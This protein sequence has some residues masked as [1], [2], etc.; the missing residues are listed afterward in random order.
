MHH[1]SAA[2]RCVRVKYLCRSFDASYCSAP[3]SHRQSTALQLPRSKWDPRIHRFGSSDYISLN[4]LQYLWSSCCRASPAQ[5]EHSSK[6]CAHRLAETFHSAQATRAVTMSWPAY[7]LR[8]D[9][10]DLIWK[11]EFAKFSKLWFASSVGNNDVVQQSRWNRLLV[12]YFF[13]DDEWLRS[14]RWREKHFVCRAFDIENVSRANRWWLS[15]PTDFHCP[16]AHKIMSRLGW[17]C[18]CYAVQSSV[19]MEC[20]GWERSSAP[21]LLEAGLEVDNETI[22]ERSSANQYQSSVYLTNARIITWRA[23]NQEKINRFLM[24]CWIS[25]GTKIT[26]KS[27]MTTN[28][29]TGHALG[30]IDLNFLVLAISAWKFNVEWK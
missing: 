4:S 20:C 14:R 6:T 15:L 11:R 9:V 30:K 16:T 18:W 8:E 19:I 26:F 23:F 28:N 22:V 10:K 12:N 5:H 29:E 3:Q 17:L 13:D 7:Q 25:F 24:G 27:D 1:Q 21:K 2:R